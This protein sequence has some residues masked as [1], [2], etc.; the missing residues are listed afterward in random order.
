MDRV[1]LHIG[2]P[3]TGTPPLQ[4]KR[5]SRY[6]GIEYVGQTNLWR[7]P[8]ARALLRALLTGEDERVPP[9]IEESARHRPL[10]ISDEALSFGEF[11]QRGAHW[12]I[13]NDPWSMAARVRRILGPHVEVVMVLRNQADWLVSW[14]RQG[15]KTGKYTERDFGRWLEAELGTS[16]KDRLFGLLR[17][18]RLHDAY[19]A[20]F[21]T[22][23]VH[24]YLYERYQAR[25]PDL[26]AEIAGLV[27]LDPLRARPLTTGPG[28]NVTGD[29]YRRVPGVLRRL[30]R[31]PAAQRVWDHLP[32]RI[33]GATRSVLMVS[34]KYH[35]V[36]AEQR[37]RLHQ[38]FCSANRAL[39]DRVTTDT[40]FVGY[41]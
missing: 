19:A 29:T 12:P 6:P 10:V 21:G 26:G 14:H 25:F 35:T 11:M 18:D 20:A 3:K 16:G 37:E 8:D 38:Y 17:Y 28:D 9:A 34:H 2:L 30:R 4:E 7:N 1:L 5:F 40:S 23:H 24:A 32:G 39:A 22:A 36:S 13:D 33:R 15:L 41:F 31:V 27:G